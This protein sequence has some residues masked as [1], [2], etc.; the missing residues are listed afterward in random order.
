MLATMPKTV[1]E[2]E[3]PSWEPEPFELPL[4]EPVAPPRQ[5]RRDDAED[6]E[7]PASRVIVID[8]C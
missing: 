3:A 4:V 8:L 5:E 7:S 6:P 2:S 1:F